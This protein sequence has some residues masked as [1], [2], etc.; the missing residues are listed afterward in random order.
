MSKEIYQTGQSFT[1]G[2]FVWLTVT[3]LPSLLPPGKQY[4]HQSTF[5]S[6]SHTCCTK[7]PCSSTYLAPRWG[8][9]SASPPWH[10]DRNSGP[11][12]ASLDLPGRGKFP[13]TGKEGNL[14]PQPKTNKAVQIMPCFPQAVLR[15]TCPCRVGS[16]PEALEATW[17]VRMEAPQHR[18]KGSWCQSWE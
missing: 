11:C 9:A 6:T 7:G 14:F 17:A 8:G 10:P 12:Q 4:E 3:P 1:C 13:D 15:H 16:K 18:E 5:V 2:S